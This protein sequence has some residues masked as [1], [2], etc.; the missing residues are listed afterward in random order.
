[1]GDLMWFPGQVFVESLNCEPVEPEATP[2]I[3]APPQ[4]VLM[5]TPCNLTENSLSSVSLLS[6][7]DNK[8][9]YWFK[10]GPPPKMGGGRNPVKFIAKWDNFIDL[11]F[12]LQD[13][14][15]TWANSVPCVSSL[16]IRV[17]HP[18]HHVTATG[19]SCFLFFW[20]L[21]LFITQF[22]V[23]VD[24]TGGLK[25]LYIHDNTMNCLWIPEFV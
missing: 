6:S 7:N 22:T 11:N 15:S 24:S 5:P 25:H 16:F 20:A 13:K 2:T 23:R 1:M 4:C 18:Y 8:E 12:S 14:L 3:D 21:C 10:I 9:V 17:L 19:M